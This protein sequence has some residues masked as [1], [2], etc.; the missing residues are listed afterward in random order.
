MHL[1]I[2]W[3]CQKQCVEWIC[4]PKHHLCLMHLNLQMLE[5]TIRNLL[6]LSKILQVHLL[7]QPINQ[8]NFISDFLASGRDE[9]VSNNP[10]TFI[11]PS[12]HPKAMNHFRRRSRHQFND[13]VSVCSS[14]KSS[15][16]RQ[17]IFLCSI[18]TSFKE[19]RSFT[20]SNLFS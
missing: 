5:K 17:I 13:A 4:M 2:N 14:H 8:I 6:W 18:F 16:S 19:K 3:Y 9:N 20:I 11:R 1:N 10:P 7:K 15:A 12:D